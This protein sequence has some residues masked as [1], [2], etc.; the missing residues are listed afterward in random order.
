MPSH[1]DINQVGFLLG[2]AYYTYI[3]LLG[4]MLAEHDLDEHCQPG[5]GSLLFALFEADNRTIGEIARELQLAKS[6]MTGLTGKLRKAG[7]AT[8]ASDP[9]DRRT[10]RIRLTPLARSLEVRCVKL[11]DEVE[12]TICR[13]LS[14]SQRHELKSHLTTLLRT[15]TDELSARSGRKKPTPS[16]RS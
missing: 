4:R 6:T 3:G 9:S 15:M 11:A 14:E 5:V 2:R 7:L 1:E 8:L 13:G 12:Q 10:T 16:S